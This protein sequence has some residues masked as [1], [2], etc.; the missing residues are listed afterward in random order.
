MPVQ[1]VFIFNTLD[2]LLGIKDYVRGPIG[3]QLLVG[4]SR[5]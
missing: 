3:Q 2:E 4:A 5:I 1:A